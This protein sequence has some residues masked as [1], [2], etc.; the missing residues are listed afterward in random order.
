VSD[1]RAT[2]AELAA[3]LGPRWA[4]C[5]NTE[6]NRERYGR[7]ITHK[8]YLRAH[9][10]AIELR[11]YPNTTWTERAVLKAFGRVPA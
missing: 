8:E 7:C 6:R 4:I 9:A 3:V 10:E 11:E 5:R 1:Q 2:P